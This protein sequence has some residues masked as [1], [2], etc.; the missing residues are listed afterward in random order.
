VKVKN[1]FNILDAAK[2]TSLYNS[3]KDTF[4][5]TCHTLSRDRCYDV[6]AKKLS[7]VRSANWESVLKNKFYQAGECVKSVMGGS[8][9]YLIFSTL[10]AIFSVF[11]YML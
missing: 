10:F 6:P 7:S 9:N 4:S 8:S 5:N 1:Y 3:I 2:Y 11:A